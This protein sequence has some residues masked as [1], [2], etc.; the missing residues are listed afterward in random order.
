MNYALVANVDRV[1]GGN[2]LSDAIDLIVVDL[3]QALHVHRLLSNFLRIFEIPL[4]CVL[5][6]KLRWLPTVLTVSTSKK[7]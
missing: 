2:I 1:Q 3:K 5:Q 6:C 7:Y 4:L